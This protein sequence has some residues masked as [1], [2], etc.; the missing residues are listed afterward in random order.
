M[1]V[2]EIWFCC[3]Q[4]WD[5]TDIAWQWL[6]PSPT[7]VET[8]S[9]CGYQFSVKVIF[10]PS[11]VP[12]QWGEVEADQR[13]MHT[14]LRVMML[15]TDAKGSCQ[16][17]YKTDLGK[18]P[19]QH[20][21]STV[22]KMLLWARNC[23]GLCCEQNEWEN[24]IAILLD[25]VWDFVQSEL[26][27][28]PVAAKWELDCAGTSSH[29]EALLAG[30]LYNKIMKVWNNHEGRSPLQRVFLKHVITQIVEGTHWSYLGQR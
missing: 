11:S 13:H 16:L 12:F 6:A 14:I 9:E 26:P 7:T 22:I 23:A 17:A 25:S 19:F 3:C 15:F 10:S 24:V 8:C 20:I 18:Y 2:V 29:W 5:S 21:G 27:K 28:E 4:D 30:I 1:K